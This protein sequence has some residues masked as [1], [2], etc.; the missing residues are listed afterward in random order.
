MIG[1]AFVVLCLLS[2]PDSASRFRRL[3]EKFASGGARAESCLLPRRNCRMSGW[4]YTAHNSVVSQSTSRARI[5]G[6]FL[7]ASLHTIAGYDIVDDLTFTFRRRQFKQAELA[8]RPLRRPLSSIA[9]TVTS[10]HR[11]TIAQVTIT[12]KASE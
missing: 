8:I 10:V 5:S 2:P 12:P 6:A 4:L 1:D 9:T 3:A 11:W 7:T